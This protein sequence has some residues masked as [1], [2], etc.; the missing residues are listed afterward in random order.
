VDRKIWE[1]L[2]RFES[3]DYLAKY[4]NKQHG[5][6][7][8][9]QR[10]HEI[11]SCFTQGREY[12]TSASTASDAVKPLLLYYG[13]A[14]LSRG[15]T[16]LKDSN[17]REESLT[18]AHGLTVEDWAKTLHAGIADVLKLK[19]QCSRG[20]FPEFVKAVGN[21]QSYTWLDQNVRT[22]GF[23][24]EFGKVNFVTDSSFISL[25]DLLSRE[26][27]LASE[28]EIANDGWGNT[29]FGHVVAL[30]SC[31]RVHFIPIQG[32]DIESAISSY[33][34]PSTSSISCRP[35]PVYPQLQTHCVEIPASGEDRKKIVPMALDQDKNVGW[36]IR[37]FPNGDN[38]IDI[39]RMFVE[40]FMLGMLCRYFP[41]KWMSLLRG[42]KGDI[43]RS[44]ILATIVRIESKFPQLL[45]DLPL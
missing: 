21:S 35:S 31:I 16:L 41:S 6:S 23:K 13:V 4:Y 26:K 39:H 5:R 40:A 24:N 9:A 42:D 7:L 36:L 33:C 32:R 20:T 10:A 15:V 17:K 22:S 29:D 8:N 19:V 44:V 11:G 27:D 45:R 12:F 38:L 2:Q 30:D 37:P 1:P 25:G 34:F 3:R 18:P 28:Y 43:A 14:S